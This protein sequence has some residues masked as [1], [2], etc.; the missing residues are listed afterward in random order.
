MGSET[1]AFDIWLVMLCIN[2]GVLLVGV[3]F[4]DTGLKTPFDVSGNVTG[5]TT[6]VPAQIYNSTTGIGL[7][8]NLTSGEQS[9]ST[10]G[11]GSATLNPVDSLF[12]PLAALW[13]FIQF[14]TGGFVFQM[15]A[16]FGFPDIFVFALQGI[17]GILFARMVI[18]WVWGR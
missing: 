10:I 11:G 14:V 3:A 4:P 18:Y 8:Q 1:I 12:F 13:T 9:N 5:I 2:A 6:G 15:I 7:T 17:I 16:L